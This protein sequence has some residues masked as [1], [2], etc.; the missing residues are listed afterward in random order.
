MEIGGLR[1]QDE[2]N[3]EQSFDPLDELVPAVSLDDVFSIIVCFG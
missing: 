1:E 3:S 2:R